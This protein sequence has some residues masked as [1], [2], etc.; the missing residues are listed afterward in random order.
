MTAHHFVTKNVVVIK[1]N[2]QAGTETVVER[3]KTAK[4]LPGVNGIMLP[5]EGGNARA[6][7][8]LS[9]GDIS[10]EKNLLEGIK[11]VRTMNNGGH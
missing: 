8:V 9:S 7:S 5:G 2:L 4:T 10:L 6:A 1:P 3:I 11:K